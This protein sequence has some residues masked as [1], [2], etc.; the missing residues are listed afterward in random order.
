MITD[1][2]ENASQEFKRE[3]VQRRIKHQ[4]DA[5][6][7]EFVYLGVEKDAFSE[8]PKLGFDFG[9]SI[10]INRSRQGVGSSW[11]SLTTNTMNYVNSS[12]GAT[13]DS[14]T[15]QQR[16]EAVEEDTK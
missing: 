1:G 5:Y 6:K 4:T 8:A 13:M 7:W 10:L 2:A 12:A 9:K 15:K 3:D 14:Y 11:G 16:D